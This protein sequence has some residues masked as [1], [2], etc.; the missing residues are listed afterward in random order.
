MAVITH[1]QISR[2]IILGVAVTLALSI[3]SDLAE[4]HAAL[5][6]FEWWFFL[7]VLLLTLSNQVLRFLKWEYLLRRLD[8]YL[9]PWRSAQIFGSGLV[10]ILTPGK[11][12][13]V[14]KSWLVQE[15]DGTPVDESMPVVAVER[16]TDL[17]GVTLISSVG[18]L[19]FGYSPSAF[20]LILGLLGG[21]LLLLQ[22][23]SAVYWVIDLTRLIPFASNYTDNV[24]TVYTNSQQLLRPVPL[25]T[26]TTISVLSWGMECVGMWLVLAGLN[27]EVSLLTASFVFAFSSILGALSLLPGGMGVTEGSM[28]GLLLL[29]G[30]AQSIA[31]STTLIVRAAT[32]WFVAVAALLVYA[33]FRS[34]FTYREPLSEQ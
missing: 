25:L 8:I 17:I 12:G 29:F 30:V 14:W 15:V 4:L 20:L 1:R 34:T 32:L 2:F 16:I 3:W 28:T 13:E 11:I 23:E 26:T 19:A 27:A 6:S 21:T 22:C 10:M 9:P 24:R 7:V 31:V 5:Q 18:V 33:S